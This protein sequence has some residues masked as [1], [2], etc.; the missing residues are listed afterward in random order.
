MSEYDDIDMIDEEDQEET[1]WT[2]ELI[3]D[4]LEEREPRSIHAFSL[5]R[6]STLQEAA[7]RDYASRHGYKDLR[8][9]SGYM[10][11]NNLNYYDVLQNESP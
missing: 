11:K 3:E 2:G 1:Q 6:A 4:A 8:E 7:I 5:E 9:F 10:M